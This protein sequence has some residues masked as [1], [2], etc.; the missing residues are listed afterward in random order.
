MSRW[1]LGIM[2]ACVS[3]L[4]F[5]GAAP[6]ASATAP[7]SG[8]AS[9]AAALP[10]LFIAGD[11]TS[12][13]NSPTAMG[14][15]I[16]F[17]DY[18]DP[19]KLKVVNGGKSGLSSRTFITGGSWEAI[20][21][22]VKVHDFVIIQFGHNDNGPVDSF[23]F[24]GTMPS[25]GEETQEAHNAQGQPE[26]VHTFGWYMRK[27]IHEVQA[28]DAIPIVVSMT[29]RNEWPNGKVERGFG[30]YAKLAGDLAKAEGVRYID[31][32]NMAA[33]RYDQMGQAAVKALF[34][35]DNTHNSPEG[36]KLNADFIVAGLKTLKD[37][38]ILNAL[39]ATGRAI[40]TGP[41]KY[42][43]AP[44]VAVGPTTMPTH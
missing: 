10:T 18:F 35:R 16:H 19:A 3:L 6:V 26:T 2:G 31:L 25:L 32:N 11:S 41:A 27:M 4:V 5:L 30:D 43:L 8:P 14:W 21:S 28:K 7:A 39:S 33:D 12:A 23:R 17:Q 29:V 13:S 42:S 34:P 38:P 9:G 44:K 24:R 1:F 15:G 40:E 37:A 22:K 36:A 20:I